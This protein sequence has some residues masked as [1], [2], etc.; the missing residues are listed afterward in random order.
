M[1]A[2]RV[3]GGPVQIGAGE[4]VGLTAA[5]SVPRAARLRVVAPF[6]DL[7]V[8]RIVEPVEFKVGEVLWFEDAPVMPAAARLVPVPEMV[9][10]GAEA[11]RR[12]R[13]AAA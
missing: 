7:G 10:P 1:N 6:G 11:P 4:V 5:Q 8:C 9:P 12:R 2:F 13:K 3:E